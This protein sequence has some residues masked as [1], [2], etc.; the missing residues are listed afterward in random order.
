ME[1]T[2]LS[3]AVLRE[4]RD[5]LKQTRR[6]LKAEIAQANVRLDLTN[7]RLDQTKAQFLSR[8]FDDS[9]SVGQ[10]PSAFSDGLTLSACNSSSSS[11]ESNRLHR[12][13]RVL[14]VFDSFL[15]HHDSHA[16][17]PR[18]GVSRT[19]APSTAV[20][21]PSIDSFRGMRIA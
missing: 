6:D 8:I 5:E 14:S 1:P 19:W 10:P 17:L 16:P 12:P 2:V 15:M 13:L 7:S 9:D 4:I 20:A 21:A 18:F 11:V 3:L